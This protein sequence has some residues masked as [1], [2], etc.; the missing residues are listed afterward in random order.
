MGKMRFV[1]LDVG[2]GSGNFIEIFDNAGKLIHAMLIDLGS[3]GWKNIAG[4]P[5]ADFVARE[6]KTM[7][8]DAATLDVVFLS[9]SDADH[10]NL[11]IQLLNHF[12]PPRFISP[13]KPILTVKKVWFGGDAKKYV[14]NNKDYLA[15]LNR[16][17]PLNVS[18]SILHYCGPNASSFHDAD[19]TKWRPMDLAKN[20]HDLA[21]VQV[22]LLIGNTITEEVKIYAES[23]TGSK[24][25]ESYAINTK[26]LVLMVTYDGSQII[27]T[28]DATGITLAKCNE[29]LKNSGI[30]PYLSDVFHLTL[31]HHGSDTTLF[32]MLGIKSDTMDIDN[33][34]THNVEQFVKHVKCKTISASAGERSS[35]RHPSSTVFD[36]F[37][38]FVGDANHYV[39][40]SLSAQG[41]QTHFYTAYFEQ[42]SQAFTGPLVD[43][44]PSTSGWVTSRTAKN[45][46]STDYYTRELLEDVTVPPLPATHRSLTTL[47][48]TPPSG[49]AWVLGF[50]AGKARSIVL[51]PNRPTSVPAKANAAA[52]SEFMIGVLATPA[53]RAGVLPSGAIPISAHASPRG[54]PKALKPMKGLKWV[55]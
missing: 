18:G 51:Q 45:L 11:L 31:P 48:P 12:D 53:P 55:P 8:A 20:V 29:I 39:E 26:S 43:T 27:V 14:K 33:L 30:L 3:E 42:Y 2:Q 23:P 19:S 41:E 54:W 4:G 50:E 17:R 46:Y 47:N 15:E 7:G 5:S 10:I 44:W 16:Y 28:G 21:G 1:V 24:P 37:G 13:T 36:A 34:A 6:L 49:V 38:E 35:F 40:P 32:G 52:E 22:W 25:P 9:H